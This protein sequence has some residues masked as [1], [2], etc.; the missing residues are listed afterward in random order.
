MK[1]IC[2]TPA[3][4]V[5]LQQ[6]PKPDKAQPGH[7]LLKMEACGINPGDKAFIGR[8]FPIGI[9]LSQY[10]IY[11]ASGVGTVLEAGPGVPADYRGKNVMVYRS[12]HASE[13]VVGTWCEYAHVP[14]LDCA[15]LPPDLAMKDYSGSLVNVITAYSFL[16]Q[17]RQEGHK[18]IISTAGSSATGIAMLGICLAY[19]IPH[20]AIVRTAAARKELQELGAQHIVAQDAPDFG[21][22]VKELSHQLETSAIFDGVGGAILN[23][24]IDLLPNTSTVYA[25]GYLGGQVPL[26]IHTSALM[27]GITL[28]AFSNF[29][30]Q[31]VQD[32]Q[33]LEKALKAISLLIAMPHFKTKVGQRFSLA[34]I[35]DALSYTSG[36]GA[37]AVLYP[38]G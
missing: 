27:R 37:K 17:I 3:G 29:R 28:R 7:L 19:K 16:Q 23:R 22:Q 24:I 10:A 34:E 35:S 13:Y 36:S 1:A 4:T 8:T 32:G 30:S 2:S 31:T 12:L 6:V 26:S 33:L 18:G 20:L 5:E 21:V 25:Y 9:V 11:G 14:F 15:I 38:F